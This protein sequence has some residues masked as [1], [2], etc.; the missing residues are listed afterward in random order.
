MVRF[1]SPLGPDETPERA[2]YWIAQAAPGARRSLF[3]SYVDLFTEADPAFDVDAFA[4]RVH[5]QLDLRRQNG[6][7]LA[8]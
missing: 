2:A 8:P 7:L 4:A 3:E 6:E 1:P 5:G